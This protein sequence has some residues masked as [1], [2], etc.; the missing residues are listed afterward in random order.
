MSLS[1]D[2]KNA[3]SSKKGIIFCQKEKSDASHSK[4]FLSLTYRRS[5]HHLTPTHTSIHSKHEETDLKWRFIG[6]IED[7]ISKQE[8]EVFIQS[9]DLVLIANPII[10]TMHIFVSSLKTFLDRYQGI[11]T[12]ILKEASTQP[13]FT[14]N[15]INV[16]PIINIKCGDIRLIAPSQQINSLS[17][18]EMVLLLHF[19]AIGISSQP[20][21]PI[22]KTVVNRNHYKHLKEMYRDSLKKTKLWNVQYQLDITNVGLCTTNWKSVQLTMSDDIVPTTSQ[23]PAVEWNTQARYIQSTL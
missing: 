19:Q 23:N 13:Q 9:F 15:Y 7:L 16:W 20:I 8:L 17:H 14:S 1:T 2:E 22:R 3:P 5:K 4:S 18:D 12:P 21:N 11:S 6:P 10:S